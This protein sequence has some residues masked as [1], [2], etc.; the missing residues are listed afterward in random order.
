MKILDIADFFSERGGGVRS[1][2]GTLAAEGTARSHEIVVVA[3]GPRSETSDFRGGR[4]IR[5]AGPAMPY[6]SSYHLLWRID[7]LVEIVRRE[8]PD[9]VQASS[10]YLPAVV[11]R[12]LRDVPIRSLVYHSD[13]IATYVHP[14]LERLAPAS[15]KASLA[16]VVDAW[17]RRLA[18]GFDITITPS[19]TIRANLVAAGCRN[20]RCV[21]FG[22]QLEDFGPQHASESLRRTMLGGFAGRRDAA[23]A[24]VAGRLAVEKRVDRIID[25]L[26]MVNERR[27]VALVILG[28]GPE[29]KR[30]EAKARSLSNVSFRGFLHDRHEYR[31]LLASADV[32]VHGG[33][34][35]TFGFVLAEA[36][37]SGLGVVVPS[38]GAAQEYAV[39][40]VS[41]TYPA[42]GRIED[43]ASAIERV[44]DIPRETR[45][46]ALASAKLPLRSQAAH[47]DELFA[48]YR[49]ML[50]A[51]AA[52][53]RE[54]AP[55]RG[56]SRGGAD[57]PPARSAV[58]AAE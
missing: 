14:L 1:Y 28:D 35:E 16:R 36:L 58:Q 15:M 19:E 56:T 43:M 23:V 52:R 45:R 22:V 51:K 37:A 7:R 11:A 53:G 57:D 34:A 10:P 32:L 47:F 38:A 30:L 42:Y 48:L 20:V 17:P 41:V 39:P 8:R 33:A 50:D 4:V 12:G 18:N 29:R 2:L 55:S 21:P 54:G 40:G 31:A 44:M 46:A 5:L 49:S 6:D 3:P 27:P 26:R 24:I 13:Q 25:A 9:V